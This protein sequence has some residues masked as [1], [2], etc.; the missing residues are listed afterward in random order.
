MALRS[1]N[2]Q[3]VWKTIGL[4]VA[5]LFGVPFLLGVGFALYGVLSPTLGLPEMSAAVLR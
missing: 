5:V 4:I 2:A 1:R 3:Q